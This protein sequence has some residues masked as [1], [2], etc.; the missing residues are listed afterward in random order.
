MSVFSWSTLQFLYFRFKKLLIWPHQGSMY[1]ICSQNWLT[2]SSNSLQVLSM[3]Q[4]NRSSES[5]FHPSSSSNSRILTSRIWLNC[6]TSKHSIIL[7]I[8]CSL[9]RLF[10]I[11]IANRS[12]LLIKEFRLSILFFVI[13][14][15]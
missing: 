9:Y 4:S 12:H 5:I 8:L 7:S 11:I 2:T 14:S 13:S 15:S 6:L 1:S 10:V 3:L